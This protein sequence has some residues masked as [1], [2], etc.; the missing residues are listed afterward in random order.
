MNLP[1][2]VYGWPVMLASELSGRRARR[3]NFAGSAV[4]VFKTSEGSVAAL[5]DRCPH[6]SAPLSLG[7]I[8]SEGL[9]CPYHG[10]TFNQS[11]VCTRVPGL[12]KPCS[13][14]ALVNHYRISLHSG[15]LWLNASSAGQPKSAFTDASNLDSMY[16]QSKVNAEMADV[17]ENFLDGFHTHF[18][19]AGWLRK[20]VN[21]Q[22]I[23]AVRTIYEHRAE[24]QYEGESKQNGWF[25]RLFEPD[26]GTSTG[27]YL[28]PNCAE[29]E[30]RN[31]K[32]NVTLRASMAL[33]PAEPG[34]THA[35]IQVATYK[36]W[37]P[38]WFK[39]VL[40]RPIFSGILSQ[41]ERMLAA[42]YNNKM[43]FADAERRSK[44]ALNSDLD[45]MAPVIQECLLNGEPASR[46]SIE[47]NVEL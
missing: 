37:L 31:S 5:D 29:I 41:D 12:A 35:F 17:L 2:S 23:R 26:R 30:Y 27:R 16:F 36:M 24:I 28:W 10:W 6:R 11:G 1:N 33:T 43:S 45:L 38:K 46:D 3:V 47:I 34:Y 32:D 22:R 9:Q 20:D 39:H 25:S 15:M 18:V 7:K 4:V 42:V 44:E 14:S 40:L 19:H 8:T 21:R 13:K